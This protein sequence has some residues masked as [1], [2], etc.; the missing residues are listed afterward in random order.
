MS[1]VSKGVGDALSDD[2]WLLIRSHTSDTRLSISETVCDLDSDW[3]DCVARNTNSIFRCTLQRSGKSSAVAPGVGSVPP[4][5]PF[6]GLGLQPPSL[7]AAH[8]TI[9]R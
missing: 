6:R 2:V 8:P 1:Y 4:G 5:L 3:V 9:S 7:V